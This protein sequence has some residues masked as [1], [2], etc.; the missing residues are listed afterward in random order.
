MN[1]TIRRVPTCLFLVLITLILSNCSSG[2]SPALGE[3]VL[4]S[5]TDTPVSTDT[6]T[7]T[8]QTSPFLACSDDSTCASDQKCVEGF[9]RKKHMQIDYKKTLGLF[10]LNKKCHVGENECSAL[11]Y[12]QSDHPNSKLGT[13]QKKK[14]LK[15]L[16]NSDFECL[17]NICNPGSSDHD[18]KICSEVGPGDGIIEP[19]ID[20]KAAPSFNKSYYLSD[21]SEKFYSK[22][23]NTNPLTCDYLN[24][25]FQY[26]PSACSLPKD[27]G[28]ITGLNVISDG[29]GIK[30]IKV[31]CTD[32]NTIMTNFPPS[33]PKSYSIIPEITFEADNQTLIS[34]FWV[35][36]ANGEHAVVELQPYLTKIET[37]PQLAFNETISNVS[38]GPGDGSIDAFDLKCKPGYAMVSVGGREYLGYY[39]SLEIECRKIKTS[40]VTGYKED[41][42]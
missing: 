12:C 22:C 4:T 18:E 20:S 39:R 31:I 23:D 42:K 3:G 37:L 36:D 7:D 29:N 8:T 21:Q 16:C 26:V 28:A 14:E 1:N 27:K 11:E 6:P 25:K 10:T 41:K 32:I 40:I 30:N 33:P 17:S 5:P 15:A 19:K 9:C 13:C 35:K 24:P 2:N 34:G 38:W